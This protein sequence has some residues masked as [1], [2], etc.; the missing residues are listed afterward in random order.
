MLICSISLLSWSLVDISSVAPV[1]LSLSHTCA[2]LLTS[3]CSPEILS[4]CVRVFALTSVCVGF[5]F[6]RGGGVQYAVTHTRY[7]RKTSSSCAHTH[8]HA[9]VPS[10][11]HTITHCKEPL[12]SFTAAHRNTSSPQPFISCNVRVGAE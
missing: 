4:A 1:S 7:C 5:V 10:L 8:T 11:T 2:H 6:F 3:H 12:G 9:H